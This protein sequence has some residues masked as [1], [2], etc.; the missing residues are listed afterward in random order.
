LKIIVLIFCIIVFFSK[1]IFAKENSADLK[2]KESLIKYK[3][4]TA[5]ITQIQNNQVS[6][7]KI[8]IAK[9]RIRLDYI[10]PSKITLVINSKKGMY[11]NEDLDEVQYFST[12]NTEA[13]VFYELFYNDFFLEDFTII[14][15]KQ[16]LLKKKQIVVEDEILIEITFEKKPFLLREIFL[17]GDNI[18]IKLGLSDHDFNPIFEKNFFSMADPT[19]R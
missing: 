15:Q 11:Y 6:I 7:G 14:N 4:F 2:F 18:D 19:L 8:N 17:K 12:K 10:N 5:I 16:L 3:N 1:S 13:L 9:K